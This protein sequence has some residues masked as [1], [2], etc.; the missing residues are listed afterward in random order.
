MNFPA[1]NLHRLLFVDIETATQYDSYD[2]LSDDGKAMWM[3]KMNYP[4][5]E[6]EFAALYQD[7]GAIYAEFAQVVCISV[8]FITED[9]GTR[10]RVKAIP[11]EDEVEILTNFHQ[12]LSEHF[13]DRFNQFL[14]GHNLKEF[15]I[16]FICRRSMVH[17][18]PLPN[19]LQ[20]AGYK[21]WHVHHLLDTMELWKYGDYKHYTSLDL[22]CHV[23]GIDSPKS[24]MD[25]SMVSQA[26]WSGQLSD[27]KKY[28]M[29]DVV[30]TAQ[31]YM[32]CVGLVPFDK[33]AVTY[34]NDASA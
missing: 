24:E 29:Q 17:N 27:I 25:G 14:C 22:L 33:G 12:L 10:F 28:C 23:L 9:E 4:A 31:V 5:F 18:L 7:K 32:R 21:P 8:G 26:Y 3:K 1:E 11:G 16:P 15:D 6:E 34:V 20:I 19:L 30:A 13:Y 2:E